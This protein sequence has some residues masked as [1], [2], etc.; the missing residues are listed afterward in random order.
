MSIHLCCIQKHGQNL[1]QQELQLEDG[2]DANISTS[3]T[4]EMETKKQKVSQGTQYGEK[5]GFPWL[6]LH[7]QVQGIDVHQ[8]TLISLRVRKLL[9]WL[10]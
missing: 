7:I 3:S 10:P 9:V 1:A 5:F 6:I 8:V 2:M 4:G